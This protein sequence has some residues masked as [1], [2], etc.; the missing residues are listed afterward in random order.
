MEIPVGDN[1][2]AALWIYD[3]VCTLLPQM[4]Q[5]NLSHEALGTLDTLLKRI[6][7]EVETSKNPVP[8][9]ALIGA[10]CSRPAGGSVSAG[11]LRSTMA[12]RNSQ[13]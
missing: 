6:Q 3:L 13:V 5:L 9:V 12:K 7:S 10:W 8:G 4:Q 11:T 1:S 2:A